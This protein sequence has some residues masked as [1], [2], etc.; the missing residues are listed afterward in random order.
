[1]TTTANPASMDGSHLCQLQCE[2]HSKPFSL[3]AQLLS[4]VQLC[5]PPWIAACQTHLSME[6]SREEH[7][8]GL[9]FP[10]PGAFP[11]RYDLLRGTVIGLPWWLRSKEYTCQS[12][13]HRFD[14]WSRRIS[15]ASGPLSPWVPHYWACALDPRSCSY[16]APS[17]SSWSLCTLESVLCSENHCNEKTAP[18]LEQ[19]PRSPTRETALQQRTRS[20]AKNK[21]T[22]V[23]KD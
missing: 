7:W 18:Q 19:P 13:R 5:A 8:S 3:S 11:S 2:P 10:I 9:P 21:Q 12:G 22:N 17:G 20:T 23:L 6:F 14:S 16:W 15:H 4:R 1:M